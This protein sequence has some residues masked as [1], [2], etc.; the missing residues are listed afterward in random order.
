MVKNKYNEN[1]LLNKFIPAICLK[2]VS[3]IDNCYCQNFFPRAPEMV[4]T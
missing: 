3:A 1:F 4:E 2:L